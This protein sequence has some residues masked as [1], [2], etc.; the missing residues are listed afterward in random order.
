MGGA[1]GSEGGIEGVGKWVVG[2]LGEGR[3]RFGDGGLGMAF[4]GRVYP[5]EG[6]GSLVWAWCDGGRSVA[7]FIGSDVSR[8][9]G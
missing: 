4:G 7:L 1:G 2:G 5:V 6:N 3:W 9:G 8:A